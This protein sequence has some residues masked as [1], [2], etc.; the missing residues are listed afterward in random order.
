MVHA[1]R[2]KK[3]AVNLARDIFSCRKRASV[4]S[5]RAVICGL[6]SISWG[7]LWLPLVFLS[8]IRGPV[9]VGSGFCGQ[10]EQKWVDEKARVMTTFVHFCSFPPVGENIVHVFEI[11]ILLNGLLSQILE[12]V[13]RWWWGNDQSCCW[14]FCCWHR[15]LLFLSKKRPKLNNYDVFDNAR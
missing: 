8:L 7:V 9:E 10:K 15:V 2:R 1:K 14:S 6:F 3:S 13:P 11:I 5:P 12:L 4:S